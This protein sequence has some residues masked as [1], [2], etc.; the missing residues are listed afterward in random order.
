MS[1]EG[2]LGRRRDAIGRHRRRRRDGSSSEYMDLTGCTRHHAAWLLRCWGTSVWDQRGGRPVKIVVGQR[3]ARRRTAR[4][5]DQEVVA[6]LI[7]LWHHF[8]YLC[9]KRLA[10]DPAPVV[11]ELRALGGTQQA[12]DRAHPRAARQ[13]GADQPGNHRP[14]AAHRETQADAARAQSHQAAHRQPDAADPD[15]HFQRV[16]GCPTRHPGA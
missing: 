6:A 10:A 8:G 7:K 9:G 12:Q 11:T 3:R 14:A 16:G 13:A 1:R 15:P 2:S 5:Y 4:V